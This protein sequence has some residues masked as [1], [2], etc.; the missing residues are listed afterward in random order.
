M[1]IVIKKNITTLKPPASGAMASARPG[2][3]RKT[4]M[5]MG[6]AMTQVRPSIPQGRPTMPQIRPSIPQGRPTMPHIRPQAARNPVP[7]QPVEPKPNLAAA[8]ERAEDTEKI[9]DYF[10]T[11]VGGDMMKPLDEVKAIAKRMRDTAASPAFDRDVKSILACVRE[12]KQLV[13]DLVAISRIDP[14]DAKSGREPVDI[15]TLVVG[16]V[17]DHM[18]SARDKGISLTANVEEMPKL[19]V[20]SHRLRQVLKLLVANSLSFTTEGRVGVEVS[21]YAGKLKIIVEDTGCGMPVAEQ[22]KFAA[23]GSSDELEGESGKALCM[24][25]RLVFSLGGD[26]SLRSTPGI[27]TVF[28]IVLPDIHVE[29]ES[30]RNFSSMQ[31]IG[32]MDFNEANRLSRAYRVLVVDSSP[33]RLAVTKGILSALGFTEVETV[34]DASD[35]LVKILTGAFGAIF[36][37][38]HTSGVDGATLVREIRKIPAYACLPVYAMTADDT[39]KMHAADM[40]FSDVILMPITKEKVSRIVG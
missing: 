30:E 8:L 31:R 28:T 40:G 34:S 4:V 1:A 32:A 35:A 20:D 27:G 38:M 19:M 5:P 10:I 11:S 29:G 26:I 7:P 14:S 25:K 12:L 36:T 9:K 23:L 15:A 37:D 2:L 18:D 21:Y 22:E 16:V 39:V 3:P 33:V 13:D 17:A 6:K 24:V